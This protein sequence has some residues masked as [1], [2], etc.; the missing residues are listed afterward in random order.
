[1]SLFRTFSIVF[2]STAEAAAERSSANMTLNPFVSGLV[3]L[4]VSWSYDQLVS[5]SVGQLVSWSVG[6]LVSWSVGQLVSW[7][8]GQLVNMSV[9]QS[10]GWS[11]GVEWWTIAIPYWTPQTL[12]V[13]YLPGLFA[14]FRQ[15][16]SI[17]PL[18][19]VEQRLARVEKGQ[20][21][22]SHVPM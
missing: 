19:K 10:A 3:G 8:D 7:S 4:S 1:M 14:I 13:P 15:I 11:Q 21:L 5:W 9:G 20:L 18:S 12:Y 17:K 2:T 22:S 6:Q 16:V